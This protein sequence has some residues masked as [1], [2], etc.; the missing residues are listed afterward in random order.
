MEPLDLVQWK[1]YVAAGGKEKSSIINQIAIDSRRIESR[2]AL[3]I[4]LEGKHHNGHEYV[5]EAISQQAQFALVKKSFTPPQDCKATQLLY[6]DHPLLALQEI[7]ACYRKQRLAKVIA[8]TGSQG[9]TMAKDLLYTLLESQT[10]CYASPESF[11]SQ[12]GVSL[13]LLQIPKNAD[14]AII[15]AGISVENEMERLAEMIQPDFGLLTGIGKAHLSTLHSQ[16]KIAEEKIKLLISVKKEGFVLLPTDALLNP[17]L[18]Q[19]Q[20]SIYYWDQQN[21]DLPHA[22]AFGLMQNNSML[23]KINFPDGEIFEHNVFSGFRYF[24][25]QLNICIKAAWL[26]GITKNTI[27]N[28]LKKYCPEPMETEIWTSPWG[29]TFINSA[30]SSDPLSVKMALGNLAHVPTH[31]RKFYL[32]KGLRSDNAHSMSSYTQIVDDISNAKIDELLLIGD[33]KKLISVLKSHSI[34]W[35]QF[36]NQQEAII[37]LRDSIRKEDTILLQGPVKETIDNLVQS[38]NEVMGENRL[39]VDLHAVEHN[40]EQFRAALKPSTRIMVMVKALAYG[41][42]SPIL[43]KFLSQQGIDILGVAHPDEG[44]ALRRNGV[45][46]DI[47]VINAALYEVEK[48]TAWQFQVAVSNAATI[49]ALNECALKKGV[50]TKVHLHVDTGMSRFGCKPE[51]AIELAHLI[52]NSK[53]LYFEGIMT[54]FAAA[55]HAEFDEFTLSQIDNFHILITSLEKLCLCPFWC[56]ASNT[57]ASL[58]FNRPEF[59]Q[60]LNMVRLGLGIFGLYPSA[61]TRSQ[62]DLKPAISLTSRI[63]GINVCKKGESISYGRT[64][65]VEKDFEIIGIVPIGYF[66]GLHRHYSNKGHVLVRGQIAPMVGTICMDFMMINITD[67]PNAAIGDPVLIFGED[68]FGNYLSPENFAANGNTNAHELITCIGPRIQRIFI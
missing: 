67:I 10:T 40:L 23:Y 18:K 38:F 4:A 27:K 9:K 39:L 13:S 36:S 48:I 52:S 65:T 61:I 68:R 55:D 21:P 25:A 34:P 60:K 64:Y 35:R 29:A 28:A 26:L 5:S 54:H 14:F 59:N 62:L 53:G 66:D 1:G 43:A 32:F 37:S 22:A 30:Y 17:Y 44:I 7:A 58:R 49:N 24:I 47:F 46:Q 15:E 45:I 2:Q 63:A 19:I 20:A 12:L 51:E 11:N 8:I 31:G 57:S 16:Q 41:T 33:H 56:H 3:F 50:L 6:V 42:D